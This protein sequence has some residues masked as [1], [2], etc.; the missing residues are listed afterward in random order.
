M[1]TTRCWMMAALTALVL[2]L[3]GCGD[4]GGE[5]TGGAD[6]TDE[7]GS[8]D[9]DGDDGDDGGGA[10]G[11]GGGPA[12]TVSLG[13]EEFT[14]DNFGCFFEEQPRAGLGG[15]FTHSAQ[16]SGTNAAGERV[17]VDMTRAR[18]EDGT[19]SDGVS[20]DIGD[21][22]SDD[23]VSYRANGPEGTIEFGEDS[24]SAQDLSAG[25]DFG[26]GETV[27]LSFELSCTGF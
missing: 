26:T 9:D 27:G 8:A 10:G 18:A 19:V 11:G 1:R 7:Q 25:S 4:D 2:L 23:S 22:S 13:D 15:V 17:V 14:L 16:G 5:A 20:V 12:G 6:V 24:A 3:A 21:P